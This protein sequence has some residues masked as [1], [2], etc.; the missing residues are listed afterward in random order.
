MT[1]TKIVDKVDDEVVNPLPETYNNN[2]SDSETETKKAAKSNGMTETVTFYC[3]PETVKKLQ[4]IAKTKYR[5]V[6]RSHALRWLIDDN[7]AAMVGTATI[8]GL[9]LL[10]IP[11]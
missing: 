11:E 5:G 2:E 10:K 8:E 6:S 1:R 3:S 7:Y 9:N 4:E